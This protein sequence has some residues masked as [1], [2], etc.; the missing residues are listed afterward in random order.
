MR[1]AGRCCATAVS[2]CGEARDWASPALWGRGAP[3]VL[4]LLSGPRVLFLDEPTHGVDIGGKQEIYAAIDELARSGLA[5]VMV[6]SELPEVLGLCDRI[7]VLHDGQLTG[8]FLR[9]DATPEAVM[10]CATGQMARA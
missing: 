10:A 3:N 8:E 4:W 9:E 7:L 6:S 5:V 2:Q 1:P